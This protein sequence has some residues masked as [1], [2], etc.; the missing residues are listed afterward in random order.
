MNPMVSGL[1][2]NAG[3]E[4]DWSTVSESHNHHKRAIVHGAQKAS[5]AVKA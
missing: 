1:W 2:K 3:F 4:F 5:G